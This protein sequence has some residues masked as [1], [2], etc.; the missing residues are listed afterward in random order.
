MRHKYKENK[1]SI[2]LA[3]LT[4]IGKPQRCSA[5]IRTKIC[6][7]QGEAAAKREKE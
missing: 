4:P 7:C 5:E 6:V 2:K 1:I 3:G